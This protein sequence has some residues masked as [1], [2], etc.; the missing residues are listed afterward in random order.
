MVNN[1][2]ALNQNNSAKS[3]N[4]R[5]KRWQSRNRLETLKRISHVPALPRI[6]VVNVTQEDPAKCGGYA[7]ALLGSK[8]YFV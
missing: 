1:I 4:L 7:F 5:V 3:E 6:C 8:I 2:I